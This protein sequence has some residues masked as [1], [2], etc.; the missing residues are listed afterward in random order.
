[1]KNMHE[2]SVLI[3]GA[4][5]GGCALLEVFY[6]RSK[7]NVVG[8]VDSNPGAMGMKLAAERDIP[9]FS[10]VDAALKAVGRCII[11]NMTGDE[12]ISTTL[13]NR[14]GAENVV[15]GQVSML[16]WQIIDALQ[17]VKGALLKNQVLLQAV[18]NNVREGIVSIN[19][20]G[21]VESAN[22][23]IEDVFGYMPDELVGRSINMLMPEPDRSRHDGYLKHYMETGEK[24]IIGRYREVVGL[25]KNGKQF[26]LEVNVAEMMLDGSKHFVGLTRDITDRKAAE[27]K[28][29]QLA[30]F[31]QMTGLPNRTMFYERLEFILS[32]ARRIKC[33]VALMFIDLDGF[34]VVN[35]MFGHAM[36]DHVLQE[37]GRR[38]QAVTR[39]SDTAARM[40]GDEFT[41]ILYNI[42]DSEKASDVAQKII[43]AINQPIEFEGKSCNVGA[44]IGIALYPSCAEAINDLVKAAD[45]AMYHAKAGGKNDYYVTRK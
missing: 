3:I 25:H 34:K 7:I 16:F 39:E 15:G 1:M 26:P 12:S 32:Q 10:D 13:A 45:S 5:P 19:T 36:G 35:D 11:F 40:G 41:V 42:Q 18:I 29:T 33:T 30:L 44:S 31:D 9:A 21:I 20:S 17:G 27:E 8:V 28:L 23:A 22:P 4:G 24:R 2:Q 37:V 6:G 38:L 14:V 43:E